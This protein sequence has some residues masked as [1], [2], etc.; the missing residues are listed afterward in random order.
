MKYST[1]QSDIKPKGRLFN[2]HVLLLRY[3]HC[4]I[5]DKVT[6]DLNIKP[7]TH[8]IAKI[9]SQYIC[10]IQRETNPTSIITCLVDVNRRVY[11]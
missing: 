4:R 1:V 9:I 8:N 7:I 2:L 6:F 10:K 11:L 5:N 3:Y